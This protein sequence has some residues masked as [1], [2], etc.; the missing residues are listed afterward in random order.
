MG[1]RRP[2]A[3]DAVIATTVAAFGV[4]DLA[5][6]IDGPR[7][8]AIA[9]IVVYVACL[10]LRRTWLWGV[11]LVA[12]TTTVVTF[13]L[14]LS[15]DNF[16]SSIIACLALVWWIGYGMRLVESVLGVCFAY[17][18]VAAT[19]AVEVTNIVWLLLV[20]GGAWGAGRALRSR[21][22]L[23]DDLRQTSAE[24]ERSREQLAARA[25]AMER[26]RLAQE[27]HDIVAHS[28]TVMLV[29]A[30]AAGRLL[31]SGQ[32]DGAAA[33]AMGTVQD[34]GRQALTE[35]R[36][37]L[38]VLRPEGRAVTSP[39]PGLADLAALA[40]S[41]RTAALD[42]TCDV[43]QCGDVPPN[44]Q[45]T[46]YRVVQEALTN[47]LRH[48]DAS[49]VGV[50][51]SRTAR[52]LQ[53]SVVD[54]GPSRPTSEPAGHGLIGMRE[55]VEACGGRLEAR[56]HAGGFLVLAQLP[57]PVDASFGSPERVGVIA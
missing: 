28:V 50:A 36:Q 44:V 51:L 35:L 8:V 6:T 55:R 43:E 54:A 25:V 11:V 24:L 1:L 48:S 47:V 42:V 45:L 20:I 10:L 7:P 38:G 12:F 41:Y 14:G 52:L 23:I 3:L 29:Q 33:E 17:A 57:I 21:R 56:S 39:A 18:C 37:L 2:S 15:Q 46:A 31:R 16:L 40:A 30:E 19:S 22:L 4:L 49:A 32:D 13:S 9:A 27:I 26:L 34:S 5:E 53:V